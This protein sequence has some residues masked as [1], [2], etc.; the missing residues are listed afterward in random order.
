MIKGEGG[1]RFWLSTVYTNSFARFGFLEDPGTSANVQTAARELIV[2]SGVDDLIAQRLNLI[3]FQLDNL[4]T[5]ACIKLLHC[6]GNRFSPAFRHQQRERFM[7]LKWNIAGR[8]RSIPH[9]QAPPAGGPPSGLGKRS[10]RWCARAVLTV[11]LASPPVAVTAEEHIGKAEPISPIPSRLELDE[12][13]VDL[14]RR[15]FTDSRLSSGNGVSCATC[16]IAEKAMADGLPVSRGLSTFPGLV[17]TPTLFN[18]SLNAKFNWSGEYLTLEEQTRMVVES[19][20]TMGGRWDDILAAFAADEQ[21]TR[22][23]RDA[24]GDGIS[25]KNAIDAIIQFEKS[26]VA[27]D[28]PFD[29]YLRGNQRAISPEAAQGYALFKNY[30]CAS[31]HQGINVGGNMLQVFGIFGTPDAAALGGDT[32]GSARGSGIADE[33]PVFRVPPLRNVAATGPYFHDGSAK[34]LRAAINTMARYQLG[35]RLTE[36]DAAK[37]EAFLNSLSGK[38]QGVPVGGR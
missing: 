25:R 30:G 23:F 38:F 10:K 22:S 31:C 28:A 15:L 6:N 11:G 27:P 19:P 3:T 36:D 14:G 29:D 18:V 7:T 37:L 26:L 1:I 12:R 33:K 21:L 34:T 17:N 32:P 8:A 24:Y 13:K 16:H 4:P 35:R 5:F 20:R 9:S 2:S